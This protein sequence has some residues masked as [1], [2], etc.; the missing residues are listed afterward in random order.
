MQEA[1]RSSLPP[2]APPLG[3]QCRRPGTRPTADEPAQDT[4]LLPTGHS[5]GHLVWSLPHNHDPLP[6]SPAAPRQPLSSTVATVPSTPGHQVQGSG[7]AFAGT[8]QDAPEGAGGGAAANHTP[9]YRETAAWPRQTG[10]I[11]ARGRGTGCTWA[12]AEEGAGVPCHPALPPS[13]LHQSHGT[14]ST[15]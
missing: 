13:R 1:E 7:L 12:G 9:Q 11:Q 4:G 2:P 15:H 8:A 6:P 10:T 14:P 5:R 3:S